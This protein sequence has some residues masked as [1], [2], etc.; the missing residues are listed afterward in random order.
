MTLSKE[1]YEIIDKIATKT[2]C[3]CWFSIQQDDDGNDYV[4]DLEENKK[5]S[6]Y[7]GVLDLYDAVK[8]DDNIITYNERR[9]ISELLNYL[10]KYSKEETE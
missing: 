3:D 7:A 5:I 6:L 10:A 8:F 2:K 4:F 1:Q 9:I